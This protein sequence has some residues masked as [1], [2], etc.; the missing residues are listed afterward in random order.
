MGLKAEQERVL[1][2]VLRNIGESKDYIFLY[3]LG[4]A[5]ASRGAY[6]YI[7]IY[8]YIMHM[9]MYVCIY[10]NVYTVCTGTVLCAMS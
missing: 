9:H 2:C 3:I 4:I 8:I 1:S 10:Y 5:R 6:I 7:Y